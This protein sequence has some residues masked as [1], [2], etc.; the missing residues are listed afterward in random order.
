[1]PSGALLEGPFASPRL[2][3]DQR[4]IVVSAK[5][6]GANAD[7]WAIDLV[8]GNPSR[9]TSDL[10]NDYFPAWMP[11]GQHVLFATTR[12]PSSA[13]AN[14]IYRTNVSGNGVDEPLDPSASV[15]GFPGD[16]SADGAIVVFH[17]LTRRGYD[18]GTA[19]LVPAASTCRFSFDAVQRSATALFSRSSLGGVRVRRV[20]PLRGLR[21]R[22]AVR[23]GSDRGFG[24]RRHAAGMASRREGALL[25][26]RGPEDHG[27]ADRARRENAFDGG[28]PQPLF[29]VDTAEPVAPYPNDYAVTADGQRF[30]VTL[31]AKAPVAQ[32]LTVFYNWTTA[33]QK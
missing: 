27:G 15:R 31:N 1:M 12:V 32:T 16:V 24:R 14:A 6:P 25:P 29:S 22:V 23:S 30:V 20:G 26:L 13:G 7:I 11:D 4:T 3:P 9:V 33:L 19:S 10:E 21:A 5:E 2:A 18:I 28:T 17:N 8:R